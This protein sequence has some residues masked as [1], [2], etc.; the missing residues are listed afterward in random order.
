MVLLFLSVNLLSFRL[1]GRLAP[2]FRHERLGCRDDSFE[3]KYPECRFL[4]T[5]YEEDKIAFSGANETIPSR[6]QPVNGES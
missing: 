5:D 4:S 3:L 1:P 6:M 2:A